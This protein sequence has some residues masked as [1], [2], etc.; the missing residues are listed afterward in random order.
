[1]MNSFTLIVTSPPVLWLLAALLGGTVF[2]GV[3]SVILSS[4]NKKLLD[5]VK[6]ARM[7]DGALEV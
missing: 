7:L 2:A 5:Q 3:L 4:S 1:M 6:R